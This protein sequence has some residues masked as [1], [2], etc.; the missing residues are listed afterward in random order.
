[1]RIINEIKQDIETVR[2]NF[3]WTGDA[4]IGAVLLVGCCVI[5]LGLVGMFG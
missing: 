4:F 2:D 5:A 1:M 3:D